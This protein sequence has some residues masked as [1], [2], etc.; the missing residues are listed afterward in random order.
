MTFEQ[1]VVATKCICGAYAA[2]LQ[3]IMA[4]HRQLIK[5]Q[6]SRRLAGSVNLDNAL[7]ESCPNDPRWD[8]AI[9]IHRNRD[10][11]AIWVEVH[12]A[13]STHIGDMLNKL[14]WLRNWLDTA[15]TPLKQLT[16][17][18]FYWLATDGSVNITP[19]SRQAKQL[20]AAGLSFPKRVLDLDK[21]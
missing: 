4:K 21:V 18:R 7:A 14:K 3:A 17:G 1:A 20:A 2:G 15:G 19:N 6:K 10:D 5:C 16:K 9:G 11:E 12:P 13:S 8:Y